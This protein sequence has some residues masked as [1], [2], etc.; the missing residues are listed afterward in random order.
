ML[1]HKQTKG[2]S[3]VR[4]KLTGRISRIEWVLQERLLVW[5]E[6]LNRCPRKSTSGSDGRKT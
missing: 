2:G 4:L 3:G 1:G 6:L 5:E